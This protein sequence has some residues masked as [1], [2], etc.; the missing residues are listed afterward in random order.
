[1]TTV[2]STPSSIPPVAS[3]ETLDQLE[4][5][6]ALELVAAHAVS[7][8]G[9]S[10][11]R[12]RQ[13]S[14]SVHDIRE[15]LTTVAELMVVCQEDGSF[16]PRAVPDLEAT[17]V[18]LETQGGVLEPSQ[19]VQLGTGLAAMRE[20]RVAL[21][22]VGDDAPRVAAL[23]V[24][25]PPV[26]LEQAIARAIEP[27]GRV[28][29]EA[30]SALKRARARVRESRERL[31]QLLTR[32]QR[33]LGHHERPADANVTVRGG[34]YVIPVRRDARSHLKGIVHGESASGATLFV[35]PPEAVE[36]GNALAASEAEEAREVLKVLRDL[37]ERA[38]EF[39]DRIE[40]GW[41]MCIRADDL[42]AR[43]RYALGVDAHVPTV[44]D[45]DAG[46]TLRD[47]YHPLIR[48]D[49]PEPVPFDLDLEGDERTI[50]VSGP[51][52]G[53]KSVLL[54]AVGLISAMVQS[55]VIPPVGAGTAVPVFRRIFSDIGD[56]QSIEA[57][58][59]TFSAHVAALKS[60]LLATDRGSLVLVDELGG[61]TDPQEGA[62]LA[63]AVLMAVHTSGAVT[64]ATTHL[65]ELKEL[66]ARHDGVVNA[67]LEFDGETLA[68]TYRFLKGKPGRSYALAIAK[69][70]GMPAEVL[71]TAD[72]LTPDAAKTLEATL[73]D[74][75]RRE[76]AL[77]R[78]EDEVS[79]LQGKLEA[80]MIKATRER[81][82]LTAG[83]EQLAA[84]EREL[85]RS[86]RAQ[87]RKFLLEAR[88]RVE[89]ALGTARA[90]VN[91]A[92]AREARRL[93]EDGVKQEGDALKRLEEGAKEKGWKVT[94][95]EKG[96]GVRDKG[97]GVRGK[98]EHSSDQGVG[99]AVQ[100]AS[101]DT[102]YALPLTPS[103][104]QI[105]LRGLRVDEAQL[106]V[107]QAIDGAVVADMPILRIIH[108]KGTGALKAAVGELLKSDRRVA[109]FKL[110]DPREGGSGVTVVEL[111]T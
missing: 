61:G 59:S 57:N 109:S 67:S 81:D 9:A 24:E 28:K 7:D 98:G 69:R 12:R 91:E 62:A 20:T 100:K 43:A 31:V 58:L 47:A 42:Y 27:D 34:R 49:A 105:D 22:K 48:A 33:D 15:E 71:E 107:Q 87:A 30:S 45:A 78:L 101:L 19:L 89:D 76:A 103:P 72:N 37:S 41:Q 80:E 96:E 25:L 77:T 4:L 65:G 44:I 5:A 14:S 94:G 16:A 17:L 56:H 86:G 18:L 106:E 6:R 63:G 23:A 104:S 83:L 51:N 64:I 3:S 68:P 36:L 85:E 21:D 102:P 13:P 53:G 79:S 2:A 84:R 97:E 66:A 10:A 8:L 32:L 50:V 55:G 95:R 39:A 40:A 108:G 110:A 38:R 73:S 1:V 92:T 70:L 88:K 74:L 46:L 75:E 90:A 11:V 60:I 99:P 29:D 54:K 93:V 111:R 52:A 35:E 82:E 26:T